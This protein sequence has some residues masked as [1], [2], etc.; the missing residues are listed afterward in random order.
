MLRVL[1]GYKFSYNMLTVEYK[2]QKWIYVAAEFLA[3]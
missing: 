3:E 2:Q 1:S